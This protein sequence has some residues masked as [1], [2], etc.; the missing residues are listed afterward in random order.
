[1]VSDLIDHR[2]HRHR[3][4]RRAR[5]VTAA[6]ENNGPMIF[7]RMGVMQAIHRHQVR[8]LGTSRKPHHRG[9]PKLK[10]NE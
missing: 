9:K 8:E 2:G 3:L 10:R 4:L 1:L 6:A 7:A 5:V